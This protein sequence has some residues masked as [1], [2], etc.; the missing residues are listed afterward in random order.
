[1]M[2]KFALGLLL[3]GTVAIAQAQSFAK[4]EVL[5]D[6]GLT[7]EAQKELID[8][9]FSPGNSPDKPKALN[10]LASIAI[11][12]NNLKAALDAWNRLIRTYPASPEAAAAKTRLPLLASV[13]GQVSEERINDATA[14][15]F[16]RN[17]DFWAKERSKIF[18]IDSSWIPNVEAAVF[19]YD[20]VIADQ[21][22]TNAAKVAYEEKMRTLLGWKE[23]GRD[24]DRHGVRANPSNY[25]PLLD[26]TFRE[27]E[28][29]F[30]QSG[31][32]QAFRFQLAQAY[33]SQKNWA[34]TRELLNEIIAKDAGANSFYKDLA[35]RRLNKVEY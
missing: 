12:K 28:K 16:L 25:M 23:P 31:A 6:N 21:A 35:E 27:Y 30:P 26:G 5:L 11:D 18:S 8:L 33:W 7:A 34:K 15:V 14:R 2:R 4:A 19:W 3:I 1:M 9:I 32:A 13:L 10:L 29:A 22:G 24:G 17:A 20:K